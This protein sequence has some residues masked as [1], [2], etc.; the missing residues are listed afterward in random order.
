MGDRQG[1]LLIVDCEE[2]R[3]D[4]VLTSRPYQ[5]GTAA[6]VQNQERRLV[7]H[8]QQ[9]AQQPLKAAPAHSHG[10]VQGL[11]PSNSAHQ[12]RQ[13]LSWHPHNLQ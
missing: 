6:P 1:D 8:P 11:G 10:K 4:P 13:C 12:Q 9:L 5:E 2:A 7:L 3:T